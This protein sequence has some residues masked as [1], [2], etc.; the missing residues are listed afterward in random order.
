LPAP[1]PIPHQSPAEDV[2]QVTSFPETDNTNEI[3]RDDLISEGTKPTYQLPER[4]NR[5]KPRVQYEA[6][7]KAKEKYPINNY[8]SLCR[9][10]EAHVHFV[11]QLAN[12]HVPNSA[13]EV[14]KD[15]K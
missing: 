12:I 13:I 8:I 14:L 1:A 4:R 2:I 7:L 10:S 3:S 11:K 15:P 6:D 9:L 5:G